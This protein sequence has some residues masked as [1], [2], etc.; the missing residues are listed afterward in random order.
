MTP[1][2][3]WKKVWRQERMR[4]AKEK[5]DYTQMVIFLNGRAIYF[6]HPSFI[7]AFG[8]VDQTPAVQEHANVQQ[9]LNY[10]MHGTDEIDR[11]HVAMVRAAR[12]ASIRA[13]FKLP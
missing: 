9:L 13:G 11:A 4:L 12:V 2:Y 7:C 10:I 6:Y 5:L 3:Y 1:K 8:P